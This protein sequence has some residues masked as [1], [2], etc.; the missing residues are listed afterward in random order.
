MLLALADQLRCTEPHA[1]TWLVARADVVEE[2]RM[3]SGALGCP[4][5][6]AE[7]AVR[8]GVVLWTPTAAPVTLS[9]VPDVS[10]DALMRVGALIGF[11][12]GAAPYVLCGTESAAAL[13]LSGLADAPLVLLDPPDNRAA[14]FATII[15]GAPRV[16][17]ARGAARGIAVD[18]AHA[19][20]TWLASCVT[21]LAPRGRLV[22][23]ASA[24][25]P[26]GIRELA[27]DAMNWVGEREP[28]VVPV[29]ITRAQH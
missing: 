24:P 12:E 20:A 28:D 27:R 21:A 15:R 26:S 6:H 16:P 18:A 17:L 7:R 4:I 25:V 14:P 5:C 1:D 10:G 13:G 23:P 2:R 3:V 29:S 22:A 8:D 9:N 19:D 11:T